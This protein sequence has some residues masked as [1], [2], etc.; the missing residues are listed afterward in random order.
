MGVGGK[1]GAG[2]RKAL[3]Y[4]L[5]CFLGRK[6]NLGK[7]MHY[8]ERKRF[9]NRILKKDDLSKIEAVL[10]EGFQKAFE[11]ASAEKIAKGTSFLPGSAKVDARLDCGDDSTFS[12]AYDLDSP[13]PVFISDQSELTEKKIESIRFS[14]STRFEHT[15]ID[16]EVTDG[17]SRDELS[18][19]VASDN[20]DSLTLYM[21]KISRIVEEMDVHKN[22]VV[23][24]PFIVSVVLIL[25][26]AQTLS[27]A[28]YLSLFLAVHFFPDTFS[29]GFHFDAMLYAFYEKG[30]WVHVRVV[31]YSLI[32]GF[33]IYWNLAR[34][35][36]KKMYPRIEFAFLP[37]SKNKALQRRKSANLVLGMFLVP[38]FVA[39]VGSLVF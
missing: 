32:C 1:V 11:A 4:V 6:A 39:W 38:L 27:W 16:I 19:S 22:F 24:H 25:M 35:Y 26:F 14:F 21:A 17:R 3:K 15:R 23:Q 13:K 5:C 30:L 20:K 2:D 37:A 36:I 29:K 12:V 33:I 28:M 7:N 9:F 8:E 31:A 34:D 10:N 18:I